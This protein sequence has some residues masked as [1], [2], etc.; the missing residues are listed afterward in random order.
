LRSAHIDRKLAGLLIGRLLTD[1]ALPSAEEKCPD[2][3]LPSAE[4]KCPDDALPSAEEKCPDDALPSAE[5]KCPDDACLPEEAD[6]MA[7]LR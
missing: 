4:E 6:V 3:A 7:E 1:D 5:E 2:D